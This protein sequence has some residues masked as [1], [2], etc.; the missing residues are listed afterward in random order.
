MACGA[1]IVSTNVGG[2]P[3]LV[4]HES[5]ALLVDPGRTRPDGRAPSS[6]YSPI[7]PWPPVSPGRPRQSR[8]LDWSAVLPQWTGLLKSVARPTDP[9]YISSE[10]EHLPMQWKSAP[11][12]PSPQTPSTT[13][14]KN[15]HDTL[16]NSP[17]RLC[18][19]ASKPRGRSLRCLGDLRISAVKGVLATPDS[20]RSPFSLPSNPAQPRE[21]F[22]FPHVLTPLR[23]IHTR[24]LRVSS[25]ISASPR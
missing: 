21:P 17:Q 4:Q 14:T 20:P 9:I 18:V 7:V 25:A 16:L 5:E 19:S 3:H 6:A 2:I 22:V 8:I 13:T 23:Q 12:P 15:D 11:R 1:C 10:E 24:V